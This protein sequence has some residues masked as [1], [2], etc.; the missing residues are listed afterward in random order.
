MATDKLDGVDPFEDA[1]TGGWH[2][3]HDAPTGG[4]HPEHEASPGGTYLPGGTIED[5]AYP[6]GG[7]YTPG[8]T[9]EDPA[10]AGVWP[11]GGWH[12]EHPAAEKMPTA[13][14][15]FGQAA[16]GSTLGPVEQRFREAWMTAPQGAAPS[17]P[18]G[19]WAPPG[20]SPSTKLQ[21]LLAMAAQSGDAESVQALQAQI[22]K[23]NNP[24]SKWGGG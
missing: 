20:Q 16:T 23:L 5:P 17:A 8:E 1:P 6:P 12:P 4:W 10:P 18:A 7:I 2:P 21:M 3:E 9:I 22:A 15:T 14:G 11:T 19:S 13:G 24:F